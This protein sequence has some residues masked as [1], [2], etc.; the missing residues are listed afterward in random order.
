[1]SPLQGVRA[2]EAGGSIAA[3]FAAWLLADYGADVVKLETRDAFDGTRAER[4]RWRRVL[5]R[6]KRSVAL[7]E[8]GPALAEIERLA[9]AADVVVTDT[10]IAPSLM[11]RLSYERLGRRNSR[12]IVCSLPAFSE[13][14]AGDDYAPLRT[15]EGVAAAAGGVYGSQHGRE[16]P[17]AYVRLPMCS[18]LAGTFAA[19]GI[20]AALYV[21]A[22]SGE[23]QKIVTPVASGALAAM[24]FYR[25]RSSLVP[26]LRRTVR[27][28]LGDGPFYRLYKASDGRWL[29]VCA[30]YEAFFNRMCIALE[31]PEVVGDERFEGAPWRVKDMENLRVLEGIFAERFAARPREWWLA[32]LREYDVPCASVQTPREFI[33]MPLLGELGLR[34]TVSVNGTGPVRQIGAPVR[35]RRTPGVPGAHVPAPGEDTRAVLSDSDWRNPSGPPP[36]GRSRRSAALRGP[37]DGVRVADFARGL[38]GPTCTEYLAQMGA[39]VIKVEAPEGDIHRGHGLNFVPHNVGKRGMCIDFRAKDGPEVRRALVR[40]ADVV[41]ASFRPQ[42]MAALGLDAAT[43][44]EVNPNAICAWLSG[45]GEGTGWQD[46]AGLDPILHSLGGTYAVQGGGAQSPM[47]FNFAFV[48]TQSGLLSM[49][50]ILLALYAR[51]VHGIVQTVESTQVGAVASL[52]AA[53]ATD[54]RDEDADAYHEYGATATYRLYRAKDGWLFMGIADAASWDAL[55]DALALGE[56]VRRWQASAAILQPPGGPLAALLEREM[57]RRTVGSVLSVAREKRLPVVEVPAYEQL[58]D[59]RAFHE[60][61]LLADYESNVVGHVV[62]AGIGVRMSKTPWSISEHVS[63]LG[64]HNTAIMRSIGFSDGRISELRRNGCLVERDTFP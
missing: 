58:P 19:S 64:E 44:S 6:G 60:A 61:G 26:S 2:L 56:D 37:L 1:M 12:I 36:K 22:S 39:E 31:L 21:R 53:Y 33:D 9:L 10:T 29:T 45:Y 7:G 41:F 62:H 28:H 8:D 52:A 59:A 24:S 14:S 17:P 34:A 5:D 38:A 49:Y 43:L 51:K 25:L 4:R 11:E 57:A 16:G 40:S 27:T 47:F 35:L 20:V 15:D 32:R 46:I 42:A 48:D 3:G 30:P 50:G 55:T 13:P 23:G 54:A 63:L 18:C